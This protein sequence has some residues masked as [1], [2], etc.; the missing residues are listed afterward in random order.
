MGMCPEDV[1]TIRLGAMLHDVGKIGVS[2]AILNK[3]E[4]LTDEEWE[5]IK[6]HPVVGYDV[7][8]PVSFLTPEHLA[9]VRSHHERLDGSGYPDG[10]R[11]SEI[12]LRVRVLAVAD[13]YDAMSGDRAY[14]KGLS[15]EKIIEE[16]TWCAQEKLDPDVTALFIE[17]I[18]SGEIHQYRDHEI[19]P[20]D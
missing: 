3:V 20:S 10:L 17:M 5:A 7:L 12:D 9:L 16:L 6:L 11:G 19:M 8:A 15:E 1:E 4:P 14:R 13:T 18:K 2:D